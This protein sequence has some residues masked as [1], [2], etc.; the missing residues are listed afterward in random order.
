[1]AVKKK[2]LP[3]DVNVKQLRKKLVENGVLM[4]PVEKKD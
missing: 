1:M 2:I 4:A 3:A